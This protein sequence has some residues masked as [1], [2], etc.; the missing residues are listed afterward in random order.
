VEDDPSSSTL[1]I[2]IITAHLNTNQRQIIMNTSPSKEDI[3]TLLVVIIQA[4]DADLAISALNKLGQSVTKLPSVGGFLRRK[5][6]MLLIGL[7]EG[8]KAAVFDVLRDT[9]RQ[10]VEFI[11][12]PL[13]S[14]PLP[15]PAPTP[16]NVGGATV[17]SLKI[18]HYEE[19]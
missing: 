3:D 8:K 11:A 9:C 19:I 4:Q 12:V 15:L 10:R 18:E 13:E 17:F 6:S 16:I 5:N 14:T 2:T 7:S 1:L